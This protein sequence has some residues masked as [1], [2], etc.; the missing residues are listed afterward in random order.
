MTVIRSVLI[1][2]A[3]KGIGFEIARQSA[4]RNF[5]VFLTARDAVKG[6]EARAQLQTQGYSVEFVELD[7][8]DNGSVQ[9]AYEAVCSKTNH[10]DVLINNAG[11]LIDKGDILNMPIE[12]LTET[13]QTN[14]IGVVRVIRQFLP[15]MRSGGRIINL[16]SELGA[17]HSMG[18]YPPA[19]SISKT[20]L[21][22]VTRQ[23]TAA[24]AG[25]G[26]AVNSMCPGW[27]RTEMGGKNATRS[28]EKG[29]E[30]AVWLA[31]EAPQQLSGKFIKDK[32]E[33]GW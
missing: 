3:S 18:S 11:I 16:S 7:V 2:G 6:Q 22:A 33:L 4:E 29:A 31:T 26:I 28:V 23:F 17:L 21:N 1:T 13:L 8:Q 15:M 19:Y 24:L 10:L 20:A 12:R 27:V 25:Q 32:K 14:T 9:R 30:T 5:R